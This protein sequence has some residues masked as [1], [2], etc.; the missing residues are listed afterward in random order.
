MGCS[1]KLKSNRPRKGVYLPRLVIDQV[2]ILLENPVIV[3]PAGLLQL[4]YSLGVKQVLPHRPRATG[5]GLLLPE[6]GPLTGPFR[7]GMGMPHGA[8]REIT[9]IPTPPIREMSG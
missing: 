8:S 4:I 2:G 7:E 5:I 1:A 3:I 6:C 9:S